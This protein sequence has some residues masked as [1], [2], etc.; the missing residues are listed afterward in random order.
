M[1][2][3]HYIYST[4]TTGVRYVEY[5]HGNNDMPVVESF[6]DIAGGAN[7]PDKHLVTPSGVVTKVTSEQLALLERNELFKRHRENGFIIVDTV[8]VDPEVKASDMEQ[9]D[10]SSPLTPEDFPKAE[11]A[12]KDNPTA[13]VQKLKTAIKGAA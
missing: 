1:A 11:D 5:S 13:R 3:A 8:K 9:R 6:V 10:D 12:D 2:E 7:V 4:M